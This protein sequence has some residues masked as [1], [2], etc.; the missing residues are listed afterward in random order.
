VSLGRLLLRW[1]VVLPSTDLES[2]VLR[3][4]KLLA[5]S[6]GGLLYLVQVHRSLLLSDQVC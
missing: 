1:G 4:S 2:I 5:Y 3:K 6:L